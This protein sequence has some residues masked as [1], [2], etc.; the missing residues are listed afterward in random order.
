MKFSHVAIGTLLGLLYHG[1]WNSR[2]SKASIL[3]KIWHCVEIDGNVS[4]DMF[5]GFTYDAYKS[6]YRKTS[7][8]WRLFRSE[9]NPKKGDSPDFLFLPIIRPQK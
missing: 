6:G 5:P 3:R 1:T 9:Y 2:G 4:V 7:F 8:L